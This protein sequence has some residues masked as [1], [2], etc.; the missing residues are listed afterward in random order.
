MSQTRT[1]IVVDDDQ[2]TV[3]LLAEFLQIKGIEVI[4]KGYD[5]LDAV[6][7]CIKLRPKI[8]FLD[9]M[10]PKYDGFYALEKIR[11]TQSD[12]IIITVTADLTEDTA[13]RLVSLGTSATI[14]KPYDIDNIMKIL[15]KLSPIGTVP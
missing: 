12:V 6:S 4:G 9:V 3:M 5:G 7:L 2:D 15:D 1:A 10:M 11:E 13:E 14:Y 8:L